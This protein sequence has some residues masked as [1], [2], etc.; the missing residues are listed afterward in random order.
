MVSTR[1]SGQELRW[2]DVL[3]AYTIGMFPM[4]DPADG[5]ISWYAPDPRGVI[6]LEACTP[7]RS[8]RRTIRSGIFAIRWNTSFRAV[9]EACA[10]R[11]E[12]WISGEIL[13]AYT[14]LH[15]RGY[16]HS[17]EAWA[18]EELAGGLYGVSVGG[19]F[20]G[21]SMFSRRTDASKVT[22]IALAERMRDRGFTLLDAQFVTP[23]L[24]RFGG[25]SVPRREYL[26]RLQHALSLTCTIYP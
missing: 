18:G 22:L 19:A 23:H 15:R 21:E 9:M 5:S 25:V 14:G 10:D 1:P 20:F 13:D 2:E 16:A 4:A 7:S 12:T 26:E 8:L 17:V 11:E 24:R 3:A 6:D